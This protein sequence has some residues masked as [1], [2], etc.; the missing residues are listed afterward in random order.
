MKRVVRLAL[1]GMA[2][3]FL[4]AGCASG[5]KHSE[6]ASSIPSLK[7]GEGRVYFLRSASMF[8]VAVQPDLRLNNEVVGESKPGGFFFVDRP[9]G[10]YVAS[11][12]TETEKTL[13]FVLDSGETKYVRSSPSMG[14]MVGRVVLELETPEKAKED[15]SS[16]SYTG[17]QV[18]TA[19]K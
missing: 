1:T 8:G 16:L 13:S 7:S 3:S 6:M 9:A 15:L 2:L 14:L 18:K 17:D 4:M 19:A 12:A 5:V 11:A 10:K